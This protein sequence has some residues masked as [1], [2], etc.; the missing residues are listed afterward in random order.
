MFERT[1]AHRKFGFAAV[2]GNDK[3]VARERRTTACTPQKVERSF[4]LCLSLVWRIEKNKV[5]ELRDFAEPLQQSTYA[6]ILQRKAPLHLQ[7]RKI[8][9]ERGKSRCCIFCKPDM[10]RAATQS[11]DPDGSSACIQV[12]KAASVDT[13]RDDVEEPFAQTVAGGTRLKATRCKKL[14]GTMGA[15]NDAHL[16]MVK[17]LTA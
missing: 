1:V 9:T 8:L 6:A 10:A 5:D 11:L 3:S 2:F 7:R 12:D 4:V 14:T 16:L 17:R 15:C 13:R